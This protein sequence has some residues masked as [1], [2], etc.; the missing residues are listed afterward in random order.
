MNAGKDGC[1]D[2]PTVRLE[3]IKNP[4]KDYPVE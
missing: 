1:R 3:L 2:V 4:N